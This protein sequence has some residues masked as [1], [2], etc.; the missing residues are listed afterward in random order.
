[1]PKRYC[2]LAECADDDLALQGQA[3][4]RKHEAWRVR[5]RKGSGSRR[6][7]RDS[8]RRMTRARRAS[9]RSV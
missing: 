7:P 6:G 5:L 8:K 2:G 3:L 1:L 9:F 4:V